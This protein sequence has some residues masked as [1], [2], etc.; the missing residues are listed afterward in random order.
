MSEFN[1]FIRRNSGC[2][3]I[4]KSIFVNNHSGFL[5]YLNNIQ[6]MSKLYE[7]LSLRSIVLKNRI[8]MSPMCQY[9]SIDGYVN[10]WH[11]VH[12][13]SRAAGGTALIMTEAAGVTPEGRIT[14]SDLGLWSD[15]HIA[16]YKKL[17]E[18]VHQLGAVAG[19]QL[20]HAGRKASCAVP[21]EGGHQLNLD[22]GGWET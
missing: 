10:D 3:S 6:S 20:A 8:V 5:F 4:E 13:G 7:P 14:P 21:W 19:I 9:S 1:N 18:T 22:H 17:V 15:K 11:M 2:L 16:G 12:Q